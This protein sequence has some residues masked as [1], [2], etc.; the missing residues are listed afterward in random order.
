MKRKHSFGIEASA[1]HIDICWDGYWLT[2]RLMIPITWSYPVHFY[3]GNQLK[4]TIQLHGGYCVALW[5]GP[6]FNQQAEKNC[7]LARLCTFTWSCYW[8]ITVPQYIIGLFMACARKYL[9]NLLTTV[10]FLW[11]AC[12]IFCRVVLWVCC[13][14]GEKH[15]KKDGSSYSV[16]KLAYIFHFSCN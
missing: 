1:P 10:S 14:G 9:Y 12:V 6:V 7:I 3:F 4:H 16:K 13:E 8:V 11:H 15:K 2:H 5:K